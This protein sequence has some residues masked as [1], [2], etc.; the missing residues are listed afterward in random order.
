MTHGRSQN[1][2]YGKTVA[3]MQP[4]TEIF[5]PLRGARRRVGGVVVIPGQGNDT[6]QSH[7]SLISLTFR[8]PLLLP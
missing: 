1:Q 7:L 3:G 8:Q 4:Q 5:L 2:R 6:F